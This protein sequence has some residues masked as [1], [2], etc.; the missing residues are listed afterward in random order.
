MLK[1]TLVTCTHLLK[2]TSSGGTLPVHQYQHLLTFISG[3]APC[4]TRTRCKQIAPGPL[5]PLAVGHFLKA[6]LGVSRSGSASPS[7][8][9]AVRPMVN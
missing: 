2:N 7:A 6:P 9:T 5:G 3:N 1:E 4:K 8:S